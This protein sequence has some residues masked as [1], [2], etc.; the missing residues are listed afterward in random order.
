MTTNTFL[1]TRPSRDVTLLTR[2]VNCSIA[3][4]LTRPSRDVTPEALLPDSIEAISTHTSLAGRDEGYVDDNTF[5]EISTHTSL[6]G[7]DLR[8]R[9]P[10]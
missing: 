9:S 7:R 3:F 10:R 8:F 4:L 5:N 1:L 6:A 2:L